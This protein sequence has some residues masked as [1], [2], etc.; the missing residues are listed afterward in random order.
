[1]ADLRR[2][3]LLTLLATLPAHYERDIKWALKTPYTTAANRYTLLTPNRLTVNINDS[4]HAL[5]AQ[6]QIDL[7]VAANWDTIAGTDY[8]VAANRAG[9]DFYIYAC[10]QSGGVPKFVISAN[11][12]VPTGYTSSNSRKIG[13]FHCLCAS[14]TL[15]AW[16]AD[17][18]IALYET[19]K[20]TVKDNYIY[21][22]TARAGDFKTHA[23][24]EPNWASI[25]NGATIVDDQITWMKLPN[26]LEGFLAGDI[27][28]DSIW[29][30]KHKPREAS[31]EGMVYSDQIGKW[32]DIYLA[33]GT[34]TSTASVNGGTISDSRT[35]L[36]FVDDGAAVKKRLLRDMEFQAIAAGSNEQTNITGSADPVTTGGHVDTLSRRMI[37]NI[38]C[39]DCCGAMYQ[40]LDEQSYQCNPDG[41][42]TAASKTGT[43]THVAA[44]GGNPIYIK[45]FNDGTPYLCSN[46]ASAAVNK[47]IA[48]GTDYKVQITHDADPAAGG[49][50][51]Y[52]DEDATQPSRLLCN[53]TVIG[54]DVYAA[55]NNPAYMLQIKHS[56]TASSLG[57][58]VNYDDGADNRLEFTSPTSANGTL[59]LALNSQAFSFKTIGGSKGQLYSQGTYGDVKLNAGGYWY[60][61][62][63]AGSRFRY[64]Y[65][66]RWYTYAYLG[67]RFAAEPL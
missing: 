49:L 38:G 37:S 56:A 12:T 34:D 9:K 65:N 27:L 29:D 53:N 33:S 15:T 3:Y 60:T 2:T 16:A 62:S 13:G 7:S 43:I 21:V 1:V 55:T 64:A 45:F 32:V 5:N 4:G 17:T 23:A 35:W 39:E 10:Q 44:P 6:S 22:C 66:Y 58:A 52:F 54:K 19:R 8:T 40:W 28:P 30:L 47:I 67:G 18:V 63:A 11:S 61:G 57:V 51:V 26:K 42:I 36:N 31:P 41:T 14:F 48:L 25:A 59:D 46:M 50:Q 20:P 24:T